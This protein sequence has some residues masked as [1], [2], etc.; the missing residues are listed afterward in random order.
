MTVRLS[1][2]C[3]AALA[4]ADKN[5]INN[6]EFIRAAIVDYFSSGTWREPAKLDEVVES[7]PIQEEIIASGK[8]SDRSSDRSTTGAFE[9][10]FPQPERVQKGQKMTCL[11]SSQWPAY[12]G[13]VSRGRKDLLR[14]ALVLVG[15]VAFIYLVYMIFQRKS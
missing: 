7:I 2:E 10:V 6:S 1:T 14:F 5:G 15:A 9:A 13:S 12:P 11:S 4:E 8:L 3:E